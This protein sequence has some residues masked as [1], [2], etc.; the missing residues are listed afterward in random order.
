[1]AIDKINKFH[2]QYNANYNTLVERNILNISQ[3]QEI[4][5]PVYGWNFYLQ[6]SNGQ[7]D[8]E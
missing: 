6:L 3:S 5:Q 7:M 4:C 2:T 8:K 1:V